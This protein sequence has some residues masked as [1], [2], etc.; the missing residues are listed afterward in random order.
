MTTA[1][2]KRKKTKRNP[3]GSGRKPHQEAKKNKA[4]RVPVSKLLQLNDLYTVAELNTHF[5]DLVDNLIAAKQVTN[6]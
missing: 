3:K 6:Q 5:F 4:F 2:I 1:Q